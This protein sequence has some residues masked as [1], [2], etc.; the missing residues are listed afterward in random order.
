VA[1]FG[2]L[3]WNLPGETEKSCET[4]NDSVLAKLLCEF[5]DFRF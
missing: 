4:H 5:H 3:F 1:Y 2:A